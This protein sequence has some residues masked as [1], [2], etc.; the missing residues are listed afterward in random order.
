MERADV[1]I[2]GGGP[3]GSTCARELIEA[4]LDAIVLDRA[5]FPR[6]KTCAGWITPAVVDLLDLSLERYGSKR[7][8]QPITGFRTSVIGDGFSPRRDS[9]AV[10]T[11]FGEPVSYGI[12]RVQF[13]D[14][15]LQR[16]GARVFEHTPVASLSHD[17]GRW[18]VNGAFEAPMLVGAGGHQCPVARHL[19]ARPNAESA[20]VAQEV[21]FR[22]TPA[23]SVQCRVNPETP[24]LYFCDDLRGYGWVF[25]KGD[26]LNI[27]LGRHD[28]HDLRG[29]VRTFV[30]RLIAAGAMPGDVTSTMKGHAYLL[31]DTSGRPLVG[32]GVV[33]IGDS[34][35]LAATMSGE[36]IR[37]AIESGMI[38]AAAILEARPHYSRARLER[39]AER[40]NARFPR[41]KHPRLGSLAASL[42]R[43]MVGPLFESKWFTKNYLLER[44]FLQAA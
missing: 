7:V 11:A 28:P 8:C 29:N 43:P 15:L 39:Y 19:G 5:A 1:I 44:W 16:S 30:Q 40:L 23:Q 18:V 12:C 31:R 3:A 27:G 35:G 20:V 2:V 41:M 24:E 33:L 21:E 37:P 10:E 4:G 38:A 25:R 13:D 17:Q 32:E 22:M 14:Y 9:D 36:G 42:I 6:D 34:A 26:V